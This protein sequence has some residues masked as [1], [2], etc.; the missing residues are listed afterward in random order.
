MEVVFAFLAK[1]AEMSVDGNICAVGAG[2]SAV[3]FPTVPAVVPAISVAASLLFAPM[4]CGRRHRVLVRIT[5]P[6]GSDAGIEPF[7]DF[8]PAL[9]ES[10][11]DYG[12]RLQMVINLFGLPI[13][14]YGVY[15][16]SIQSEDQQI[17]ATVELRA[18]VVP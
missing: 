15:R 11:G 14:Q 13:P 4:E 2:A 8:N 7:V 18:I 3:G 12:T 6:D 16:V 9:I 17:L 10:M 1:S 5:N